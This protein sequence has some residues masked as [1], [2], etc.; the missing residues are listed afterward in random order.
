MISFLLPY[1]MLSAKFGFKYYYLLYQVKY[2][3]SLIP[4]LYISLF[5]LSL[6]LGLS[7]FAF[8]INHFISFLKTDRL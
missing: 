2:M 7:L 8:I 5:C 1:G 6:S 3:L 4:L